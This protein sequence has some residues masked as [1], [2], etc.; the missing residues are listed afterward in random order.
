MDEDGEFHPNRWICI[1]RHQKW[2]NRRNTSCKVCSGF[3]PQLGQSKN[4]AKGDAKFLLRTT[5]VFAQNGFRASQR[6]S[7]TSPH[8]ATKPSSN[9]V[10]KGPPL[11]IANAHSDIK[12][13][14]ETTSDT[15]FPPQDLHQ[16]WPYNRVHIPALNPHRPCSP[17]CCDRGGVGRA[18]AAGHPWRGTPGHD[19]AGNRHSEAGK[20]A[21]CGAA[22]PLPGEFSSLS[23]CLQKASTFLN[24]ALVL[25]NSQLAPAWKSESLSL[26][27]QQLNAGYQACPGDTRL[28][29]HSPPQL[30]DFC[31]RAAAAEHSLWSFM[32]FIFF[33]WYFFFFS[34]SLP[35][36]F[37]R[38]LYCWLFNYSLL[39]PSSR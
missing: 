34:P 31:Q 11:D 24:I 1:S 39:I 19:A 29:R 23:P 36:Q 16:L 13:T 9:G 4:E 8:V 17:R 21:T 33:W 38:W 14:S 27:S 10:S 2:S 18:Q 32:F 20:A 12:P 3:E 7:S 37:Y 30:N 6:G 15:P 25:S 22:I 5:R 28:L 26:I 35:V